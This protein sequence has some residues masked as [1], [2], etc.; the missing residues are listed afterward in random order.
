MAKAEYKLSSYSNPN[1]SYKFIVSREYQGY[2]NYH[3]CK[4]ADVDKY[5]D[6]LPKLYRISKDNR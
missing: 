1:S 2:Y 5:K 6:D 3:Y 4:Q